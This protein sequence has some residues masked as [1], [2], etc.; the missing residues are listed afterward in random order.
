MRRAPLDCL[1]KAIIAPEDLGAAHER[2]R[3]EDAKSSSGIR[4]GSKLR[5]SF[6]AIRAGDDLAWISAGSAQ[7]ARHILD[8]TWVAVSQEPP[9]VGGP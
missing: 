4:L 7:G 1:F 6:R 9:M 5:V 3:P 8:L 2:R